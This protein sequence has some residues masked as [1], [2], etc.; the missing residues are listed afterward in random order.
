[1]LG[2]RAFIFLTAGLV[3]CSTILFAGCGTKLTKAAIDGNVDKATELLQKGE[4]LEERDGYGYNPLLWATYFQHAD[5]VKYLLDMGADPNVT[6]E[7][8]YV[9]VPPGSTPLIIASYYGT[10]DIVDILLQH[11]AK[12]DIKNSKGY[13][14]LMYA[15]EYRYK[16]CED[17]LEQ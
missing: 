15:Q 8:K 5:M 14:A 10:D 4:D 7:K 17:L 16:Y 3:A 9:S 11:G 6:T 12:K 1:M 13:T 2:Q